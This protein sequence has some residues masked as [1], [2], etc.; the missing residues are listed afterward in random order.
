M[1]NAKELLKKRQKMIDDVVNFV[2]QNPTP[3]MENLFKWRL[4]DTE[5]DPKP[6]PWE[7][8]TNMDLMEKA[9][10]EHQERYNPDFSCD[11]GVRNNILLTV[12]LGQS[13]QHTVTDKDQGTIQTLDVDVFGEPEVMLEYA[14]DPV[15]YAWTKGAQRLFPEGLTFGQIQD[16]CNAVKTFNDYRTHINKVMNEEYGS[17]SPTISVSVAPLENVGM[18]YRGLK[19]FSVDMRRKPALFDEFNEMM[20]PG[21]LT[22]VENGCKTDRGNFAFNDWTVLLVHTLMSNKQFERFLW[23]P[24]YGPLY[25]IL[26][27]YKRTSWTFIEG[28][29][30]RLADYYNEV[31]RGV[32]CCYFELDDPFEMRKAMPNV[33]FAYY[34]QHY[35]SDMHTP[36]EAVDMAKKLVEGMGPGYMYCTNKMI[37]AANDQKRENVLAVYN[38]LRNH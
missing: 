1:E 8:L 11:W 25:E 19:N 5:M 34:P 2:P 13:Q 32:I 30:L 15:K 20:A 12:A 21:F 14:A 26:A 24:Y 10:R 31:P 29:G 38:Y 9:V 6:T 23:K 17:P 36:E 7:F 16:A 22:N 27:K 18:Y 35:L 33:A 4:L 28:S 37:E 3:I